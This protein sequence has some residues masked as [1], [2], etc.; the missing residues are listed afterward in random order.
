[1]TKTITQVKV[2]ADLITSK[3]ERFEGLLPLTI[4][5]EGGMLTLGTLN[6]PDMWREKLEKLTG[7]G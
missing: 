1:M 6:G 4:T 5:I 7:E 3:G 2:L